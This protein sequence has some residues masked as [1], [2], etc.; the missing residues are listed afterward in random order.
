MKVD[1][2]DRAEACAGKVGDESLEEVNGV[3]QE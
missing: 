3:L 1:C 2:V